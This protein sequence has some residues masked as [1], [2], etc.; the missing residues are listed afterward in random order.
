MNTIPY[1]GAAERNREPILEQLQGL[2]PSQGTVLE[3]GSGTGQH[4]LFFSENLPHLLWQPSDRE[5]NLGGL[6]TC[7]S[8]QGNERIQPILKLDVIKDPWPGRNG[9]AVVGACVT[10]KTSPHRVPLILR[11]A[12][13]G[14]D[15]KLCRAPRH[16][17][18]SVGRPTVA[19]QRP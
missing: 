13:R 5:M 10:E 16:K 19:G 9:A 17:R 6:E 1:S 7:F 12:L 18:V 14:A 11:L 15:K 8:A 2:L 3:I 4:A